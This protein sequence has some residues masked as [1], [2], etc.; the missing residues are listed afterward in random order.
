VKRAPSFPSRQ[1]SQKSPSATDGIPGLFAKAV[2]FRQAGRLVEA[3]QVCLQILAAD[4]RHPQALHQLGLIEAQGGRFEVAANMIRRAIASSGRVPLFHSD[5]G[6][7]L[8]NQGK[9]D[10][11]MAC[12]QRALDIDPEF[13]MAVNNMGVALRSQGKLDQARSCY[14]R[15]LEIQPDYPEATFNLGNV[16]ADLKRTDQALACYFRAVALKPAYVEAHYNLGNVL[17]DQRRLD[18]AVDC[19]NRAL[20]LQPGHVDACCNLGTALKSQ[21]KLDEALRAYERALA[22]QPDHAVAQW[23]RSLVQLLQGNL[24]EGLRNYEWRLK[25]MESPRN[26]PQPQWDGKPLNGAR[27][28]LHTEQGLGDCLQFLR[29]LPMVEAAGGK[30][31]IELPRGM[32]RMG[33][34][35]PGVAAVFEAGWP[36]PQFEFHC[37]L[38]SL[39]VTLGTTLEN[40]PAQV[41]YLPVP[42]DALREATALFEPTARLRVGLVWRGSPTHAED[43]L[44][45]VSFPLLEP[46]FGVANTEFFSLQLGAGTAELAA[47]N[48]KITDLAPAISD[49]ADTAA[50]LTQLDL[51]ITVDTSVAHLAGALGRPVWV[52]L[53]HVPDWRWMMDREDSP[54]YPTMRLF[55]QRQPDDWQPVIE[56]VC[57]ELQ[58]LAALKGPASPAGNGAEPGPNPLLKERP[59][60]AAPGGPSLLAGLAR[61]AADFIPA[62]ST[63]L[64]LGCGGRALKGCLS[65]AS[66]FLPCDLTRRE[67]RTTECDFNA[68]AF[69]DAQAE[70]ADIV[71][72]L[73]VLEFILDPRSFL[74]HLRQWER[75]M[76]LTYGVLDGLPNPED[77]RALGW[78]NDI[79]LD[80]LKGLIA[81]AGFRMQQCLQIDRIHWLF[82]LLPGVQVLPRTKSVGVLSCNNMGNFGDRLGIDLVNEMLPAHAE[83]TLLNHKPWSPPDKTFDLLIVGIGNS[84]FQ[85]LL[86]EQL[87]ALVERSRT[88]I[89]IFGTQY[90][91][92]IPM[93]IFQALL[94]R[95]DHWFARYEEDVFRYGQ[96]SRKVTHLGDWLISAF[97]MTHPTVSERLEIGEEVW[98]NLPLDRTIQ[99]I[100]RHATVFSARLHPLL[101]ALTSASKV[102]YREQRNENWTL[103]GKFRSMLLDVFGRDYPED[104]YFEVDRDLV[105]AYKRAVERRSV[106][107]RAHV[108]QILDAV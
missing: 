8:H 3:G 92:D 95:L 53:Q 74:R 46:L 42:E 17:K 18:E 60:L 71:I 61:R 36:Q 97:P 23:N 45:S 79:S 81:E 33:K 37:P 82:R 19:Y 78:V 98:L 73:G 51:L 20:A 26:F 69:P 83:V 59:V 90:H 29:Y 87:L 40:I 48:A 84:M 39:P 66:R 10:E 99:F 68:G 21:K 67:E 4:V 9:L 1:N 49:V 86:N 14:E 57:A 2:A 25:V 15:A 38:M 103:S 100:H 52:L 91:A 54:W 56:A 107:L 102:A 70:E 27:I 104:E 62:G 22:I 13:S 24:T 85:P 75:P 76:V 77:R 108:R 105:L 58:A 72:A 28:L 43:N 31:L 11:A 96:R 106:G 12:Y 101:C 64:D 88:T 93:P 65:T 41:P 80:E 30:I 63:V 35:L 47:T 94:E 34:A 6:C 7:L 32:R 55:R 16:L 44:R 50:L 5:L 89:G